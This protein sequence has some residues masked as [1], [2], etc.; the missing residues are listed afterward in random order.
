MCLAW[1]DRAY[2]R[3]LDDQKEARRIEAAAPGVAVNF[4]N[5]PDHDADWLKIVHDVTYVMKQAQDSAIPVK[6]VKRK[7]EVDS[8]AVRRNV[9]NRA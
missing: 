4:G 3:Y 6:G 9:R 7:R 2:E 5:L 1:W 8:S